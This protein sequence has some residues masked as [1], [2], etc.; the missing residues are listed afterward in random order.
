MKL[1]RFFALLLCALMI[2][3]VFVSCSDG[4]KNE[5]DK[6]AI[7]DMYFGKRPSDFDPTVFATNSDKYQITSLIYEGLVGI[8][9]NGK[10]TK[11][12]ASSW[13]YEIDERED[14]LR[15]TI[16]LADKKWSDG[17][18]VRADD[19]VYAW[20]KILA[21]ANDNPAAALLYPIKNAKKVKSGEVTSDIGVRAVNDSTLEIF[22][23]DKAADIDYFIRCL[24]SPMLV[25][26]REDK[27]DK[28]NWSN[29]LNYLVTNGPFAIKS[30][31][32][33]RIML[34]RSVHYNGLRADQDQDKYVKPYRINMYFVDDQKAIDMFNSDNIAEKYYF[35][36][37]FSKDTYNKNK[38]S[39]KTNSDLTTYTYYFN[40][41]NNL[42]SSVETRKALSAALDRN[43]IAKIRGNGAEPATGLVPTG[44][45]YSG[46]KDDFRAKAGNV[47]SY[48]GAKV[49]SKGALT[50]VYNK[51]RGYEKE[52]AEYAKK[53]WDA[54]GFK[55]TLKGVADVEIDDI[56]KSGEFDVIG[57][58]IVS[59]TDD[60]FG[61]VVP[62]AVEFS[63]TYVD[64]RNPDVFYNPHF[65]GYNNN[66][67]NKKIAEIVGLTEKTSKSRASL[68]VEAEKLLMADAPV[69]P[70][71]FE[72]ANY[73]AAKEL[74]KFTVDYRGAKNFTDANL[75]DYLE[76]ND[77]KK[78]AS[79]AN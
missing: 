2:T 55:I 71:F 1:K 64:V 34:E 11:L 29:Q 63:G 53:K 24:A 43:E 67:Y 41:T 21:P 45:K 37:E 27:A 7:I 44:V 61:F 39:I 52:I 47:L 70:L 8:D 42:L 23:E 40:T 6:G 19:Y 54:L 76:V 74:S 33:D 78:L 56:I 46:T 73:M 26:L 17:I 20:R 59:L 30:M 79:E 4:G 32:D 48:S 58:D 25:P 75:K 15:L 14:A 49:E 18:A 28:E 5:D 60:A 9:K 10:V 57:A 66:T 72:K 65:T 50:L 13:E 22:F 77:A 69:A 62:F 36:G 51:D 31:S 3:G 16:K 38:A 68:L 35:V 12:G